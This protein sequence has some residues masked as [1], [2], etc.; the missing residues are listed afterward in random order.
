MVAQEIALNLFQG[1]VRKTVRRYIKNERGATM[2]EYAMVLFAVLVVAAGLFK[3]MG[4]K[5]NTGAEKAGS[6]LQ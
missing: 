2:T 5:V 4:G 3:T 6:L 1:Q